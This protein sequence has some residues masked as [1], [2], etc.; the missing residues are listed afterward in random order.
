MTAEVRNLSRGP[1]VGARQ[2]VVVVMPGHGVVARHGRNHAT[3]MESGLLRSGP[4]PGGT[5][6]VRVCVPHVARAF[7]EHINDTC[8]CERVAP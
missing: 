4:A 3:M 1:V 8:K 2:L 6:L 5:E 7:S